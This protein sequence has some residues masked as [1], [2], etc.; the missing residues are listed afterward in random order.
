MY[1]KMLES[2]LVAL[3]GVMIT[4]PSLIRYLKKIS[5]NQQVSEYSLEEYKQKAKTPTMGGII[6]I[7]A[8]LLTMSL[9][10]NGHYE[11]DTK[12]VMASFFAYGMIGFVDDYLIVV[13][14][15]NDGLSARMKFMMQLIVAAG[16][17]FMY[18]SHSDFRLA[19][20]FAN[21]SVMMG[22]W[23]F[24]LILVM[25]SGTSNAVN[26]TDGMDGLAAGCT[27]IALVPFLIIAY[28][29]NRVE[30]VYF[31]CSMLGS[32]LGYLHYNKK[33][34]QVFMGDTGSLA[35][36]GMLAALAMVM[37]KEIALILIGGIFVVETMCV[38][39]QIG[40]VKLRGKRVFTYTPIH[41]AFVIKG[42]NER[43]V[44]HMFFLVELAFA[45]LGLWIGLH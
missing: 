19:I 43:Q 37:H 30:L 16:F 44:V 36:G 21:T 6:F 40:S 35:L 3:C 15:N 32:L 1:F 31:I 26:L 34:A 20:P 9:V 2:F 10:C 28:V 8:P 25:F 38:M 29:N 17:Y 27:W 33:P 18:Q 14:K 45:L 24:V 23:Y 42:M 4:T 5:F 41:Y 22:A 13:K 39:I 11:V 7:V 12:I